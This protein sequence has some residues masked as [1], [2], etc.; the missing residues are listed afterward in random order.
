M[1]AGTPPVDTRPARFMTWLALVVVL[2]TD[3]AYFLLLRSQPAGSFDVWTVP[4]LEAYVLLLAAL[5][6]TSLMPVRRRAWQ[7]PLRAAAAGGLLVLGILAIASIGL[8]LIIAG[9]MATG[10]TVC[11]LRG[12]L[13]TLSA[14]SGVAAAFL[15]VAVLV[16]GFEVT[17]RLIACPSSGTVTGGGNGFVTG[18]YHYECIDGVLAF[19]PGSCANAE[20]SVD[21]N[22]HVTYNGC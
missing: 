21:A 1:G 19:H 6:A 16:A 3:L 4:F 7:M 17:E 20:V 5:L 8:P 13:F 9:A 12:P 11:T 14:L 2:A 10:A 22:G 15:S 18:P